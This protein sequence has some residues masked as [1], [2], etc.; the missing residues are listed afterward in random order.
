MMSRSEQIGMERSPEGS[1]ASPEVRRRDA[2]ELISDGDTNHGLETTKKLALSEGGRFGDGGKTS[3]WWGKSEGGG[4]GVGEVC[5]A[6]II[7]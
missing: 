6:P 5:N 3:N 4:T 1:K 2:T 7:N